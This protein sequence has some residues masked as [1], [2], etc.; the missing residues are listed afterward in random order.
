VLDKTITTLPGEAPKE[1]FWKHIPIPWFSNTFRRNKKDRVEDNNQK[2]DTKDQQPADKPAVDPE[3]KF[4]R[5][6]KYF[7]YKPADPEKDPDKFFGD[8]LGK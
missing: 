4:D 8:D 1:I 5:E 3:K 7:P 2:K 6:V